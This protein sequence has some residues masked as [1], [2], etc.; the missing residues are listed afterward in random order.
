M[1]HN[2]LWSAARGNRYFTL[3]ALIL[4]ASLAVGQSS[5]MSP[6]LANLPSSASLDVVVQ[7]HAPPTGADIDAANSVG[8]AQGKGLGLIKS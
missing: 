3:W 2:K 5:K 1:E 6:D 4:T 8:A 7:Y